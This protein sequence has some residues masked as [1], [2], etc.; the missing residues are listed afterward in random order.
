MRNKYQ[1]NFNS[2]KLLF[3]LPGKNL[4]NGKVKTEAFFNFNI[5]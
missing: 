2:Y 5:F 3:Y 1:E 4:F